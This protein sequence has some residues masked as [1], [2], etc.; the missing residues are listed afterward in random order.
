VPRRTQH[1]TEADPAVEVAAESIN[2]WP[3]VSLGNLERQG[4]L[5]MRNGFPCGN[6]NEDGRGVIQLRPMNVSPGGRI[7]LTSV[8]HI[9]PCRDVSAYEVRPGDIILNNTNSKN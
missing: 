7:D 2:G 6:N 3:L 8:K 4:R 5:L 1:N 9:E